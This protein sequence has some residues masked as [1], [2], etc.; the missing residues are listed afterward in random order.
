MTYYQASDH[1]GQ[2]GLNPP[3]QT[4]GTS[5]EHTSEQTHTVGERAGVSEHQPLLKV[6]CGDIN[7]PALPGCLEGSKAGHRGKRWTQAKN[8]SAAAGR[9]AGGHWLDEGGNM[10][11]AP[12]EAARYQ[13][14]A[15]RED[16]RKP[17]TSVNPNP[18][19]HPTPTF[20]LDTDIEMIYNYHI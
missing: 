7:F 2:L 10:D 16:K 1:S 19:T 5:A 13:T 15:K 17:D 18:P 3:G 11:R 12:K 4:L 20:P 14:E 6:D 9:L 8:T